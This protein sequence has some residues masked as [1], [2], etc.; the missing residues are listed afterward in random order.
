MIDIPRL[1]V[2]MNLSD[3]DLE[4]QLQHL[5]GEEEVLAVL[6]RHIHQH[7]DEMDG[8]EYE[9]KDLRKEIDDLDELCSMLEYTIRK[10]KDGRFTIDTREGTHDSRDESQLSWL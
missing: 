8:I 5:T 4:E 7:E 10:V 9:I 6:Q 2:E 1:L 3:P